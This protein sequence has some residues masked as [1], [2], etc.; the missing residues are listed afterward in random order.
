MKRKAIFLLAAALPIGFTAIPRTSM[1]QSPVTEK[2]EATKIQVLT[3]KKLEVESWR[4]VG[5]D[6][7]QATLQTFMWAV[8]EQKPD[9]IGKACLD[10]PDK[11]NNPEAQRQWLKHAK[12]TAT[13]F[14]AL[15]IRNVDE[16]TVDLKFEIPGWS[17]AILSQKMKKTKAGWKLDADSGVSEAT[18]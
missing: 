11:T 16:T 8:R 6:T 7:P 17:V 10:S 2:E 3:E 5:F 1:S 4:N 12:A 15:A 14:R 9:V 18:W 13:S